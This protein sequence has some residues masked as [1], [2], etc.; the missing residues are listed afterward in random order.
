M[1]AAFNFSAGVVWW[2]MVIELQYLVFNFSCARCARSMGPEEAFEIAGSLWDELLLQLANGSQTTH[3]LQSGD[4]Y[5][6]SEVIGP[7]TTRRF[8]FSNL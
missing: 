2:W 8:G 7:K 5:V 1:W 3:K 4:G 6:H